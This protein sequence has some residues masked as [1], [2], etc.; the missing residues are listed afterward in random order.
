ME[1]SWHIMS[2]N[3]DGAKRDRGRISLEVYVLKPCLTWALTF[4]VENSISNY[5]EGCLFP[6]LC[7]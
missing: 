5:R 1:W 3:R 4:E 6:S 7:I 2:K